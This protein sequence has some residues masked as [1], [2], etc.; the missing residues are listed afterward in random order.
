[1]NYLAKEKIKDV[2]PLFCLIGL[3]ILLGVAFIRGASKRMQI[4]RQIS[5]KRCHSYV[6][7][8]LAL[9]I[10]SPEV[11]KIRHERCDY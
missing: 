11:A 3:V 4:E 9:N 7:E 1:M 2:L 5:S 6:E 8:G 10:I